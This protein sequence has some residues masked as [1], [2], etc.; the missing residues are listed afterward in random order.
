MGKGGFG[1]MGGG[2]VDRLSGSAFGDG[3]IVTGRVPN[4]SEKIKGS[5]H[6]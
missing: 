3:V 2:R 1:L 4:H 6:I 5:S